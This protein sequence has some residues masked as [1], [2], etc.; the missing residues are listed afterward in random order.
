MRLAFDAR[1]RARPHSS[2]ARVLAL[3]R[4]AAAAVD[5]PF[6]EW[7]GGPCAADVLWSPQA[8][9]PPLRG[10]RLVLSVHDVNPLLADGRPRWQRLRREL[11]FRWRIARAARAAWRVATDSED[12]A[13]RLRQRFGKLRESLRVVPL[14]AD[15]RFA[16][17]APSPA[18]A[19]TLQLQPGYVL[20]LG[21]LRRHKNWERLLAAYA[22]LPP[23][24]RARHPL[25]LAGS[26]HRSGD[27]LREL[28]AR[29]Q[30]QD[31]VRRF[32]DVPDALV[33]DLYRGAALFVFP[34][35]MEGF[36]LPPLEAMACGVPVVASKATCLPEVLGNAPLFID[37]ED[38]DAMTWAMERA[39]ADPSLRE[40][41]REHG[42]RRAAAFHP[43]RTGRA[44]ESVLAEA[45]PG[46]PRADRSGS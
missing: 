24:V 4:D 6:E 14:Y 31:H 30:L 20:Y 32:T 33:L 8:D 41:L 44:I 1:A 9:P 45:V 2:Y 23:P 46:N 34:S 5:L 38:V 29:L 28:V 37:P 18:L 27:R 3:L 10:P 25:V 26:A 21:A 39:L 15:R 7:S 40:R 42:L 43:V 13:A 35:L 11:G 12:A 22:R 36:G 19:G 16:P 17:G